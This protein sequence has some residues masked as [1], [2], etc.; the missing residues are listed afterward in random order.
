MYIDDNKIHGCR[1][2]HNQIDSLHHFIQRVIR[3][4]PPTNHHRQ[5]THGTVGELMLEG[6]DHVRNPFVHQTVEVGGLP[7]HFRHHANLKKKNIKVKVMR[8]RRFNTPF[9]LLTESRCSMRR[10]QWWQLILR[11]TFSLVTTWFQ[12]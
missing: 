3:G 1:D 2:I 4:L 11:G 10:W 6:A 5:L 7:R 9:F 12:A 8:R